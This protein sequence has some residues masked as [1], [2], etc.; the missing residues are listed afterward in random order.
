IQP[1][2][3]T[4]CLVKFTISGGIGQANNAQI[5]NFCRAK[6]KELRMKK[7]FDFWDA[8]DY[9]LSSCFLGST[10]PPK[11]AHS[12]AIPQWLRSIPLV[13][14]HRQEKQLWETNPSIFGS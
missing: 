1:S 5:G 2:G 9:I 7:R 8:L 12:G 3:L 14:R 10:S 6:K 13:V 11:C 4:N